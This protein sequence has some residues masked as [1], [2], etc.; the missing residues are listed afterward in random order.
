MQ[1]LSRL[2]QAVEGHPELTRDVQELMREMQS[3]DP[4]R[5]EIGSPLLAERIRAQILAGVEQLE[6]QL[7]RLVDDQQAGN[8]RSGASQPVPP[9]YADAVAEYFRK[10]S[11][12]K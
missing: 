11:K 7:R 4:R 9:G 10:L 12:E 6:L 8:V 5:G 1:N 2:Q 3:L